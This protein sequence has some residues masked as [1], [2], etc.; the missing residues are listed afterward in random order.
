MWN[1]WSGGSM[2][3][4][5]RSFPLF[6]KLFQCTCVPEACN[7]RLLRSEVYATPS[8]PSILPE[9]ALSSNPLAGLLLLIRNPAR[10]MLP[11]ALPAQSSSRRV[12]RL[13]PDP[14]SLTSPGLRSGRTASNT[15][16]V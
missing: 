11:H 7:L 1:S 14:N 4:N 8:R 2:L 16:V 10:L 5:M 12:G 6:M 9:S 13:V 15:T 3:D